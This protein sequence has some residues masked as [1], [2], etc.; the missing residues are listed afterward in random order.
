MPEPGLM[1]T[2]RLKNE[3]IQFND[4]LTASEHASKQRKRLI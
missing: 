2:A 3:Y 4:S 1:K